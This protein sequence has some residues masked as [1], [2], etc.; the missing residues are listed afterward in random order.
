MELLLVVTV[1]M[2]AL[3]ALAAQV[4]LL[5]LLEVVL[6]GVAALLQEKAGTVILDIPI[7]PVVVVVV[8]H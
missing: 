4:E 6:A 7:G 2:A 8:P 5:N 3:A 1:E